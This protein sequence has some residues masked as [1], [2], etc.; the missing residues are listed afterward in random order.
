MVAHL[1]RKCL[2]HLGFSS[3]LHLIALLTCC[4]TFHSLEICSHPP[5]CLPPKRLGRAK[6]SA[7]H[8]C[9]STQQGAAGNICC[10]EFQ[11]SLGSRLLGHLFLHSQG[12]LLGGPNWSFRKGLS[13]DLLSDAVLRSG[14]SSSSHSG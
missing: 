1:C 12:H 6:R 5:L 7:S 9:P 10:S 2:F 11:L 4:C 3:L 13:V 8:V 14:R